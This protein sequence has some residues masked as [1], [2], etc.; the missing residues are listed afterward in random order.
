MHD[1]TQDMTEPP[2]PPHVSWTEDGK[3]GADARQLADSGAVV[4]GY[5]EPSKRP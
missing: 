3:T 1:L 4:V 2:N 5:G